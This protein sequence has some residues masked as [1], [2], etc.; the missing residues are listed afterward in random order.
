MATVFLENKAITVFY[1]FIGISG[2]SEEYN[3]E[4]N[5]FLRLILRHEERI[6]LVFQQF[7]HSIMVAIDKPIDFAIYY[8]MNVIK[9]EDCYFSNPV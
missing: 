7:Q 6:K 3:K 5:Y 8:L 1:N 4:R 2:N 9:Q